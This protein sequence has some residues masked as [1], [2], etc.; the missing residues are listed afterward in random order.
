MRPWTEMVYGIPP[1][2]VIGSTIKRSM[3]S[4]TAILCWSSAEI[5]LIDDG[6]GKPVW[7]EKL[8]APTDS[9]LRQLRR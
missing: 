6:E 9:R 8:V 5:F 3:R 7:I 1:E 4:G 2:Q